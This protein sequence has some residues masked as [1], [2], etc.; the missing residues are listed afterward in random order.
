MRVKRGVIHKKHK[1]NILKHTRGFRWR[2]KNTLKLGKTAATHALRNAYEHRR[3]KKRD[4]RQLWNVRI[5][6]GARQNGMT[7][8]KLI[9][10][11]KSKQITLNRKVLSELAAKHPEIFAAIVKLVEGK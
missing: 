6:A 10:A 2:R 3:L 11:L 8:S 9:A 1:K 5:N 4:F 7:Y